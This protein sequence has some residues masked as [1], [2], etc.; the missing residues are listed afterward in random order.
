MPSQFDIET[1]PHLPV[2]D[3]AF[4]ALNHPGQL[5]RPTLFDIIIAVVIETGGK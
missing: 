4:G 3:A 1:L 2:A 5:M